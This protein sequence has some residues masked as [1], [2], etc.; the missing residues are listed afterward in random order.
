MLL[1]GHMAP[2]SRIP[3]CPLGWPR[4]ALQELGAPGPGPAG[5]LQGPAG[6]GSPQRARPAAA[7]APAAG[8]P[9]ASECPGLRGTPRPLLITAGD[10]GDLPGAGGFHVCRAPG[11]VGGAGGAAALPALPTAGGGDPW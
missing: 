3:R 11:H 10:V 4:L 1:D 9:G 7:R 6:A 8:C 5:A 2:P